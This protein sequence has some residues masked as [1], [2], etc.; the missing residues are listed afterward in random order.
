MMSTIAK[1][2]TNTAQVASQEV[3][4]NAKM[5]EH[6][7][8]GVNQFA[9][10]VLYFHYPEACLAGTVAGAISGSWDL[11]TNKS[12][13]EEKTAEAFGHSNTTHKMLKVGV[14]FTA[15]KVAPFIGLVY[16]LA[17]YHS[18]KMMHDL[19]S[20][21]FQTNQARGITC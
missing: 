21:S 3:W 9:L 16:P 19:T 13:N 2:E 14:L 6:L 12:P 20:G 7:Y 11:L 17:F 18:F 10:A 1:T 15:M 8:S 5:G 4:G